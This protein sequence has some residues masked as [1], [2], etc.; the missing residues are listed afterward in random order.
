MKALATSQTALVWQEGPLNPKFSPVHCIGFSCRTFLEHLWATQP[1]LNGWIPLKQR[2]WLLP[3]QMYLQP[4]LR[5]EASL[6]APAERRAAGGCIE[7]IFWIK[8]RLSKDYEWPHGLWSPWC[9]SCPSFEGEETQF[10]KQC[11]LGVLPSKLFP[12][13]RQQPGMDGSCELLR[14]GTPIKFLSLL[15]PLPFFFS[16]FLYALSSLSHSP[17]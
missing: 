15:Y 1:T 9:L 2:V 17:F 6:R 10:Y 4:A 16:T 3:S 7:G 5:T 8:V 12:R 14:F 11:H 13:H